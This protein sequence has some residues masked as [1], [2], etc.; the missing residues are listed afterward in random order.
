MLSLV[1]CGGSS[2]PVLGSQSNTEVLA[3]S[4]RAISI[5]I[6]ASATIVLRH[7][8]QHRLEYAKGICVQKKH[9]WC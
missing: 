8:A 3:L 6:F 5:S 1:P 2:S 7:S 4:P 9:I